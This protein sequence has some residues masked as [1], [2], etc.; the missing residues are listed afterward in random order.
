[1]GQARPEAFEPPPTSCTKAYW[2]AKM[3]QPTSSEK[4]LAPSIKFPYRNAHAGALDALANYWFT[5]IETVDSEGRERPEMSME[6][7]ADMALSSCLKPY[8]LVKPDHLIDGT[9]EDGFNVGLRVCAILV[10]E[11]FDAEA[12]LRQVLNEFLV[13][14]RERRESEAI[15]RTRSP[16]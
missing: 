10:N 2:E 15:P 6:M 16:R 7:C 12:P 5:K 13:M 1:M 4:F 14:I 3:P 9:F 8:G 11:P